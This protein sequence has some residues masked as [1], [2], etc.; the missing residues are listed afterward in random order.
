MTHAHDIY[1]CADRIARR[2]A[3]RPDP[4]L[5]ARRMVNAALEE[6]LADPYSPALRAVDAVELVARTQA[7]P[8][9][10]RLRYWAAIRREISRLRGDE[11]E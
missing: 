5:I 2:T 11:Q 7:Q 9:S 4:R 1:R 3:P 10:D 8:T 6:G